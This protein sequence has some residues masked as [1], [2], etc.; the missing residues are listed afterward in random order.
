M[1]NCRKIRTNNLHKYDQC[2][3]PFI[4]AL[5]S[6]ISSNLHSWLSKNCRKKSIC[7]KQ[8]ARMRNKCIKEG[9]RVWKVFLNRFQFPKSKWGQN[10]PEDFFCVLPRTTLNLYRVGIMFRSKV[11]TITILCC[12]AGTYSAPCI[13][14]ENSSYERLNEALSLVS[15]F[16]LQYL[17]PV[18]PL[19]H[20]Q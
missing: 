15:C 13:R 14:A 10:P 20:D 17:L 7:G 6:F 9:S 12:W 4:P 11:F 5:I 2:N 19:Q 18:A 8:S 16:G 1:S 3:L